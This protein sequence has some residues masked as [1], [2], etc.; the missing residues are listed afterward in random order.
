MVKEITAY[1]DEITG[2]VFETFEEAKESE[3]R[4]QR[5]IDETIIGNFV[6]NLAVRYGFYDWSDLIFY[7]H[8][9]SSSIPHNGVKLRIDALAKRGVLSFPKDEIETNLEKLVIKAHYLI[10]KMKM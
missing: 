9:N 4:T 3:S 5:K 1:K 7:L 6:D 8:S 10:L 2:K